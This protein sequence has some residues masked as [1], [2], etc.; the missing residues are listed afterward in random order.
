GLEVEVT[1]EVK[2][3]LVKEGFDE[4]YGAR[5]L[6]RAIQT[7]IEDPLSDEMLQGK[8]ASGDKVVATAEEGRIVLKK[9]G[10]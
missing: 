8:F 3:I 7:L 9:S 4:A 5:P 2:E 1:D 10:S 6:R